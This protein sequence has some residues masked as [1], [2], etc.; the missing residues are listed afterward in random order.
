MEIES[1]DGLVRPVP[2]DN[3][4]GFGNLIN[5]KTPNVQNNFVK[6]YEAVEGVIRGS[7][8]AILESTTLYETLLDEPDEQLHAL[9][10]AKKFQQTLTDDKIESMVEELPS[11]VIPEGLTI[12]SQHFQYAFQDKPAALSLLRN[13]IEDGMEGK[14]LFEARK[15]QIKETLAWRRD[16][17]VEAMEAFFS[18]FNDPDIDPIGEA[19][20]LWS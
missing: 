7:I 5:W 2:L 15:T 12:E 18:D 1:P 9:E 14:E 8:P 3:N 6:S 10:L 13:G 16:H 11:E 19:Q 20:A 4:S 17:L